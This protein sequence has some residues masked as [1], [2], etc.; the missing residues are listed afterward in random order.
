MG[1]LNMK[2]IPNMI[3][4]YLNE[5]ADR[6]SQGRATVMVGA[7][8]S[9][10]AIK[11]KNT[12]K[13]FLSWNELGDIFYEKLNR[14][15]P[16]EHSGHYLDALRLA[17]MIEST[18]GRSVLDRMLLDNLP[19]EEY[20]PSELHKK[21]LKL[22]WTD[23]FTT[24]YDTLLERTRRFI[25]NRKYQVVVNKDDLACVGCPRI[26]KL[27]GSFPSE[28]PFVISQ[29]DYRRYPKDSAAFVNTVQQ[30]LLENIM[31]LI[32]FS[33][34]D[35][36]FLNWIGWIRDNLGT[37]TSK[38][39]LITVDFFPRVDD[40]LLKSRNIVIINMAECFPDSAISEDGIYSKALSLF[41]DEIR[42]R[43]VKVDKKWAPEL[44]H[45]EELEEYTNFEIKNGFEKRLVEI[46]A[47]WEE[48]RICYPGWI[49]IPDKFRHN[50]EDLLGEFENY[51][52]Y[53]DKK[54]DKFDLCAYE[55]LLTTYD[56][57]RDGCLLSLTKEMSEFYD[58]IFNSESTDDCKFLNL[59]LSMLEYYRCNGMFDKHWKL[60]DQ[61]KKYPN[62]LD[63]QYARIEC[64]A[65]YAALYRFDFEQL[66]HILEK[67]IND[68]MVLLY[69]GLMWEC[70]RYRQASDVLVNALDRIRYLDNSKVNIKS[71][72]QEAYIIHLFGIMT[73]MENYALRDPYEEEEFAMKASQ[74]FS[75]YESQC[76]GLGNRR[77]FLKLYDCDPESELAFLKKA[78]L[79]NKGIRTDEEAEYARAVQFIHFIEKSGMCMV[80]DT[81][82]ENS[83]WLRDVIKQISKRNLYWAIVLSIRTRE[84]SLIHEVLNDGTVAAYSVNIVENIVN[85]LM[86]TVDRYCSST[87]GS[88]GRNEIPHKFMVWCSYIP[89]ILSVLMW[90]I[91]KSKRS[92][93]FRWVIEKGNFLID[94]DVL[95][96]RI[97]SSYSLNEIKENLCYILDFGLDLNN[98]N[99]CDCIIDCDIAFYDK[100]EFLLSDKKSIVKKLIFLQGI[101]F[102]N[103]VKYI[104]ITY[105]LAMLYYLDKLNANET[106]LLKTSLNRILEE[107]IPCHI[108]MY[109]YVCDLLSQEKSI[110][111]KVQKNILTQLDEFTKNSINMSLSQCYSTY[112][113]FMLVCGAYKFIWSN[114]QVKRV[115]SW[116][117]RVEN[118]NGGDFTRNL[119]FHQIFTYVISCSDMNSSELNDV[120]TQYFGKESILHDSSLLNIDQKL[121]HIMDG[122]LGS[123]TITFIEAADFFYAGLRNNFSDWK[124]DVNQIILILCM[125]V[126]STSSLASYC[127]DMIRKIIRISKGVRLQINFQTIENLL[128]YILILPVSSDAELM[129]KVS[130][131]KLAYDLSRVEFNDGVI[132]HIIQVWKD[133]C[134]QEDTAALIRK[135]WDSINVE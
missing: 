20:E 24:N 86:E 23:V 84:V 124:D 114:T 83:Q 130:G 90:Y 2:D 56:W 38:L 103:P 19:D 12:D 80:I 106:A 104:G 101:Y 13:R 85:N 68:D 17:G 32:G 1:G 89:Q 51:F 30:A 108:I 63:E 72:S 71:L 75:D 53:Y 132:L 35:P 21:L 11:V 74:V 113:K 78:L 58:K 135:E 47:F 105:R 88:I 123:D 126:R 129:V 119:I 79:S 93:V 99:L 16:G 10:N 49:I 45:F 102:E 94:A 95:L 125:V 6:L 128:Q 60:L 82:N 43:Q 57:M 98:I 112:K 25:A 29:E 76:Y 39:Y 115:L 127:V 110:I 120:Y 48:C 26:I 133:E 81:W 117:N 50:F 96:K 67:S 121:R 131:A 73:H 92:N 15:R 44:K 62:I 14:E 97:Y 54:S 66:E 46:Y 77:D 52:Q 22:N 69:V 34:D 4:L 100:S 111:K 64:E 7:G 118:T 36:N 40:A 65:A 116:R 37:N 41:M 122:L 87:I 33:G 55:K 59:K 42:N 28:R 27:H 91:S 109:Y 134:L 8:F 70:D 31:C 18:F 61:L 107:N 9:K 5:I 3:Q